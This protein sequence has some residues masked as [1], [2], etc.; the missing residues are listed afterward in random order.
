MSQFDSFLSDS[1]N[2]GCAN[3]V[4]AKAANISN[5]QIISQEDHDVG[6]SIG[7]YQPDCHTQEQ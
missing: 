2:V 4:I 3:G 5:A 1:V 6:K 7:K